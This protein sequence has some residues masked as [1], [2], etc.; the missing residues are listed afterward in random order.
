MYKCETII[1]THLNDTS[2]PTEPCISSKSGHFLHIC[3]N[4]PQNNAP[5]LY[6]FLSGGIHPPFHI[7]PGWPQSKNGGSITKWVTNVTAVTH[8]LIPAPP[9]NGESGGCTETLPKWIHIQSA[10][11]L[12]VRGQIILT[13]V[14]KQRNLSK[15]FNSSGVRT[16][17]HIIIRRHTPFTYSVVWLTDKQLI[18][19]HT[20][21][22][23]K[24]TVGLKYRK[25][26]KFS[27][28]SGI[29]NL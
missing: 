9:T 21:F 5:G 27:G 19:F 17:V 1:L 12:N 22:M 10:N 29:S 8:H 18:F 13:T 16:I 20:Q 11:A 3:M 2:K 6:E 14:K 25:K 4:V 7:H 23:S 28:Y 26:N 24:P 15:D